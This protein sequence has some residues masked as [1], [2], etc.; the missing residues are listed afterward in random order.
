[1]NSEVLR[2]G[3]VPE[4]FAAPLLKLAE[5]EWGQ[6]H[7]QLVEQPSGT[8]QML[9]S[10]DSSSS[11]GQKIDI[12]VAL[13]EAL[14]AGIAKGRDDY[15]LVGSYV[16]SSLNWAIITGTAKGADQ[17]QTVAD[18][19]QS[20]VGVSRLGSGS[21][22]MAS[23]LAL[24]QGWT[25]AEGKVEKQEFVV[26]NDFKTLREGVNQKPGEWFTT[27]P[28]QDSG[29]VRFVDSI[30]TPWPSWTIAASK[31]TVLD[32][33]KALLDEF[34]HKLHAS[35][36]AFANPETR[37]KKS[38]HAFIED[39]HHYHPDDIKE[40]ASQVR[41]AGESTPDPDDSKPTDPKANETNAYTMSKGML[42]HTLSVLEDAGVLQRPTHDWD[43]SRFVD[44]SVTRLI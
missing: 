1:M 27:K 7:L 24:S 41:W 5:S 22:L 2:V 44:A 31:A 3:F 16:R 4:H 14:I 39:V 9:S 12:A 37:A 40:W 10:L 23:V 6:S 36:Q 42:T 21:H 38:L 35:I 11:G 30:P 32:T 34:L 28:F 25:D 29:E 17:Y 8:G 33:R 19:R 18:L 13:T 26:N 43:I 20:K 15:R